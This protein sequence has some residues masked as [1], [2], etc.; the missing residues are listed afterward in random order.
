[1]Q[2][3]DCDVKVAVE[4]PTPKVSNEIVGVSAV[5][6]LLPSSPT[7]CLHVITHIPV[8]L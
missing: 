4:S 7:P 6:G 3:S 2:D 5:S 8:S 1:M